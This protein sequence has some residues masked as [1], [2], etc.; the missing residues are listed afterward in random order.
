MALPELQGAEI[1]G[2]RKRFASMVENVNVMQIPTDRFA[3]RGQLLL[4]NAASLPDG[5]PRIVALLQRLM[6]CRISC[7]AVRASHGNKI[8]KDPK[9]V[10]A[11]DDLEL[12]LVRLPLTT[13]LADI[14]SA[15]LELVVMRQSFELRES[16]RARELLTAFALTGESPER[17]PE[18]VAN[19]VDGPVWLLDARGKVLAGSDDSLPS[20]IAGVQAAW[21]HSPPTGPATFGE[22]L[23]VQPVGVGS[24]LVGGLVAEIDAP[25][26]SFSLSVLQHA[27]T[28]A[29]LQLAHRDTA[30]EL[31]M[32]YRGEAISDLLSGR[33]SPID[34]TRRVRAAGWDLSHS[35]RIIMIAPASL[36]EVCWSLLEQYDSRTVAA[37]YVGFPIVLT[38]DPVGFPELGNS[39]LDLDPALR[40]GV[41]REHPSI[42]S[43]ADA[44]SEAHE[45]LRVTLRFERKRDRYH[46][47]LGPLRFLADVPTDDIT[48]FLDEVLA[49]LNE[50]EAEFRCALMETLQAVIDANLNLAQAARVGGWH[51]NTL[52]YRV[53]RLTELFGPFLE[54]GGTLDSLALALM[55]R[56]EVGSEIRSA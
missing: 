48:A 2:G 29:G 7:L 24:R 14:Q 40:F 21:A 42:N 23:V 39:L 15:V 49:P 38:S 27:S 12:P 43:F 31:T 50:V 9:L 46:E 17:L 10:A 26:G 5:A 51:Y 36:R 28:V 16:A 55:L 32:G 13:H 54:D 34:A 56:E 19:L 47:K 45:A 30:R 1:I 52:R 37:E 25:R 18:V 6:E 35:Y 22:G 11:A 41:S 3:G 4:T 8:L 44:V 53:D 33:L 20:A